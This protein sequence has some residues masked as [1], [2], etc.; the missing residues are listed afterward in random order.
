MSNS[1]SSSLNTDGNET[2]I[3]DTDEGDLLKGATSRNVNK[4]LSER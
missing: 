3:S 4:R 2:Q 1:Y